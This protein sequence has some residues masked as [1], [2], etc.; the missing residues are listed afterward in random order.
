MPLIGLHRET[1]ERI[2][3]L[4]LANPRDELAKGDVLCPLCEE[5]M[6]VAQGLIR[7]PYFSHYAD[8]CSSEYHSKPES[9]EHRFFKEYLAAELSKHVRE[10]SNAKVVIEF[11][12]PEAKRVADI[13]FEFSSG[14]VVAHEIQLSK[15]TVGEI[16]ERT[17]DYR[18][19]GV[20]VYWWLGGAGNST[21]ANNWCQQEFGGCFVL[22]YNRASEYLDLHEYLKGAVG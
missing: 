19:A 12:V 16:K 7:K 4:T 13:A 22:D 10:Y 9:A 6:Y 1:R 18:K 3:I 2:N 11:P 15:I 17:D 5:V 21:E 20:D 8:Q 14:W